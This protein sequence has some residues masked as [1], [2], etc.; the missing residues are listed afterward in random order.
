MKQRHLGTI[1][2]NLDRGW[3]PS[4]FSN[5]QQLKFDD[6]KFHDNNPE[7][8][9]DDFYS[10]SGTLNTFDNPKKLNQT[11]TQ[12]ANSLNFGGEG[13]NQGFSSNP[14]EQ[15]VR[16]LTQ[17]ETAQKKQKEINSWDEL[18]SGGYK[19]SDSDKKLYNDLRDDRYGYNK[20]FRK[21]FTSPYRPGYRNA[22]G[23]RLM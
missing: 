22:N 15:D 10:Y 23:E 8:A 9:L 5:N 2:S 16:Q 1:R 20:T 14:Q 7:T 17:L 21:F 11:S 13:Y 12:T 6:Y 3:K 18:I 19:M 4:S